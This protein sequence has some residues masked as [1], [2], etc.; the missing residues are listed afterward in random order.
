MSTIGAVLVPLDGSG[1]AEQALPVGLAIARR[2]GASL[3]LVSVQEPIPR[4]VAVEMRQYGI[5]FERESRAGLSRYLALTAEAARSAG[6]ADGRSEVVEGQPAEALQ[7]YAERHGVGLVV[8]TTHARRGLSRWWL[9]SVAERMV[10][11]ISVPVLLLHP[12]KGPQPTA[13]RRILVALDG[14]P[15]DAALEP[16]VALGALTPDTEYLL[17]C[18]AG[19][20]IPLATPLEAET[21]H[22]GRLHVDHVPEEAAREHV[23]QVADRLGAR[24]LRASWQVVRVHDLPGQV[25]EAAR[26]A[27][28]DCIAIGN[29][30]AGG[31]ERLLL[32]NVSDEIVRKTALPVLVAPAGPRQPT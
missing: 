11:G 18:M 17:F 14:E 19:L 32:G 28:A 9:G 21:P 30:E 6:V 20:A 4:A 2:S 24:G 10:R 3:H 31:L 5:E 8:M 13:F 12:S 16:A 23:R 1:I 25:V 15:D 7:D 26:Q 22:F 27:G 29:H